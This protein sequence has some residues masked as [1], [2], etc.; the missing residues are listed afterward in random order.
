MLGAIAGDMIG[1]EYEGRS[2]GLAIG[3]LFTSRST[4]TDDTVLT[5]AV[6]DAILSG[7][8]YGA[9]LR[10]WALRYPNAGYGHL[11]CEWMRSEDPS[12]YN[13][14]GNGSA[15]RA[16]AI[17]W[18]FPQ[19]DEVMREAERSALPTHDHPEGIAGAQSVAFAVW[20]GRQGQDKA[21]I[22]WYLKHRSGQHW[23][24][25]RQ[26]IIDGHVVK[27]TC[28]QTIPAAAMALSVSTDF[29]SAIRAAIYTGGDTDTNACVAGAMAEAVYGGVPKAIRDEVLSRLDGPLLR[30]VE[31]F[32]Q[33]Y[34]DGQALSQS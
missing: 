13:S 17:G 15:M 33:S 21:G 25:T 3:E 2:P 27:P 12:P 29:E 23:H 24:E 30:V 9:A 7:K 20:A 32:T 18:A 1:S 19:K 16:S 8:P 28:Q 22:L 6:A 26:M 14:F 31:A 34:C 10:E 4:A 5:V 11:F